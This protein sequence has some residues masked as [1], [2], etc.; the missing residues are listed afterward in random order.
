MFLCYETFSLL[1]R[2]INIQLSSRPDFHHFF[3][4]SF[5]VI[6]VYLVFRPFRAFNFCRF[7]LFHRFNFSFLHETDEF[8]HTVYDIQDK[9]KQKKF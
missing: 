6:I 7:A 1:E 5:R 2:N 3:K 4:D 8:L 9:T